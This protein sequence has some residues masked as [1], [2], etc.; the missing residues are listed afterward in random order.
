MTA[1]VPALEPEHFWREKCR[2]RLGGARCQPS[3]DGTTAGGSC[4]H[5]V[6]PARLPFRKGRR[7]YTAADQLRAMLALRQILLDI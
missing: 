3:E 6:L 2:L 7:G 5:R 1:P 4:P